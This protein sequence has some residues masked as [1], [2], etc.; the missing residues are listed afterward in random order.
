MNRN[1]LPLAQVKGWF[2]QMI[3]QAILPTCKNMKWST[4]CYLR[5]GAESLVLLPLQHLFG[6]R[7][8]P[9]S[10][11]LCRSTHPHVADTSVFYLPIRPSFLTKRTSVW[12]EC[13]KP[14]TTIYGPLSQSP[15][16]FTVTI[17]I[18][19]NEGEGE[20]CWELWKSSYFSWQRSK[21]LLGPTFLFLPSGCD[22]QSSSIHHGT[23]R[24][25]PKESQSGLSPLNITE[26]LN[27][28]S[29]TSEHYM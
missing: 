13:S 14:I 6:A 26:C 23:M 15:L 4:V 20:D 11:C 3:Q 8:Y 29:P 2:M 5:I 9:V 17:Y 1:P 19:A 10:A 22:S 25:R 21:T 27:Q 28:H 7:W 24:K 16:H 12:W 18:Q